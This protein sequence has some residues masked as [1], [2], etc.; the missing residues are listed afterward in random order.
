[1]RYMIVG[2]S[3]VS[4]MLD[5][6]AVMRAM[7]RFSMMSDLTVMTA[8]MMS[9][10]VAVPGSR[11]VRGSGSNIV[12]RKLHTLT[13]GGDSK[14]LTGMNQVRIAADY[15]HI[16]IVDF[17]PMS[18]T[19]HVVARDVP[20]VVAGLDHVIGAGKILSAGRHL[21]IGSRIDKIRIL[22][23]YIRVEV[24]DFLPAI[25]GTKMV[26]GDI[27]EVVALRNG[28]ILRLRWRLRYI[29]AISHGGIATTLINQTASISSAVRHL[30][31]SS[32]RHLRTHLV[33]TG[34]INQ[35]ATTGG[36]VTRHRALLQRAGTLHDCWVLRD[37]N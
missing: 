26:S 33:T 37:L 7:S 6:I 23:D 11:M 22:S 13:F 9:A 10:A 36:G 12:V 15:T 14:M 28:I 31:P 25:A 24:V 35:R 27:P 32:T 3:S 20:Q 16:L 29:S 34:G 21:Q 30:I 19:A 5:C 2:A 8:T 17:R 4:S 1:M 18:S